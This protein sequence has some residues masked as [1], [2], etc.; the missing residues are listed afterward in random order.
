MIR[1]QN[2]ASFEDL[3][4]AAEVLIATAR[5][6]AAVEADMADPSQIGVELGARA[7]CRECGWHYGHNRTC[8]QYHYYG[9]G[10]P[11]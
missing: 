5:Q 1:G 11:G 3:L 9:W 10:D 8:S 4:R 7:G 2:R 6:S